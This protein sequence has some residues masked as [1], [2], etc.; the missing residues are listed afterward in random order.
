MFISPYQRA[1]ARFFLRAQLILPAS[2]R[3]MRDAATERVCHY[4]R[5]LA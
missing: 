2:V 1:T 5:L 3:A 4:R